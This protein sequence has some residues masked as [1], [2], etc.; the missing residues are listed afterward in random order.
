MSHSVWNRRYRAS[1]VPLFAVLQTLLIVLAIEAPSCTRS[2]TAQRTFQSPEDAGAALVIAARSGDPDALIAI[3]GPG[4]KTVLM[5]EDTSADRAR[6]QSFANSYSQMHRW[7]AI[8]AGGQVLEVGADNYVFPIPLG[9]NSSGQWY[10]DTPAGRDEMLARRIGKNELAAMDGARAIAGAERHYW[11]DAHKGKEKE[12][13]QKF[14]SD[15]GTHDGLYWE[16]GDGQAASPLG[17]MG[18]FTRTLS[19]STEMADAPLFN[20]YYYRILRRGQTAGGIK[21]YLVNGRMTGGFAILAY[22]S[23]Y[24]STGV[25]SFLICQDGAL[26]QKDLG[27][28]T[29]E[30]GASMSEA[31]PA[32]GWTSV[33]TPTNAASRA[34]E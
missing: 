4:S 5:T 21:D 28:R 6:L 3:F 24:R 11:Q 18:D 14:I 23:E 9:R 26:S 1:R 2:R 32:D 20:G 12:Y 16:A 13:A 33:E 27:D 34:K 22:P 7:K 31:N 8:K 15:P 10:F 17:N 19:S 29:E 25:M 30:L